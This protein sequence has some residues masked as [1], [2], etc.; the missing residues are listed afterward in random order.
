MTEQA[1]LY[2]HKYL[3]CSL[4]LL[5]SIQLLQLHGLKQKVQLRFA[6]L[7]GQ[8]LTKLDLLA[9]FNRSCVEP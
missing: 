4:I 8:K 6:I 1:K 3:G 9:T 5:A 7:R 2:I